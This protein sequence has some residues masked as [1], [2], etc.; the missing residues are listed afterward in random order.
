M[1]AGILLV[2]IDVSEA[3]ELPYLREDDW[4]PFHEVIQVLALDRVLILRVARSPADAQILTGLQEHHCARNRGELRT[5]AINHFARGDFAFL[6]WF[7]R[8][9]NKTAVRRSASGTTAADAGDHRRD[10]RIG[11]DDVADPECRRLH[12]LK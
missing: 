12:L 10:C 4:S 8:S 3:M 7:E 11:F 5:Q 9:V 1:Q 6:Q 2:A